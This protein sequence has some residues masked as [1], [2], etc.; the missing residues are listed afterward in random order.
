MNL[1]KF[2]KPIKNAILDLT[3]QDSNNL[4]RM[5]ELVGGGQYII[6]NRNHIHYKATNAVYTCDEIETI[7][8]QVDAGVLK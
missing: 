1:E 8:K 7:L 3:D 5:R 2:G 4:A 6:R